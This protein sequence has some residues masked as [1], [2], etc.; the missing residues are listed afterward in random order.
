[1]RWLSPID[2]PVIKVFPIIAGGD[3]T[4]MSP[5]PSRRLIVPFFPN[6]FTGFPVAASRQIRRPSMVT[7]KILRGPA[8]LGRS[9][10]GHVD[11]PREVTSEKS[12]FKLTFGSNSHFLVPEYASSAKTLPDG[13]LK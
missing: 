6:S 9:G 13:V 5:M 8:F 11:T 2:D 4:L 1:S 3:V 10:P 12:D 7:A